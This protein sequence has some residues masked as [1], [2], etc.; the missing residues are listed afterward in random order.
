MVETIW[1]VV[2]WLWDG[3]SLEMVRGGK[4]NPLF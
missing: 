3:I 2:G 4:I 1:L